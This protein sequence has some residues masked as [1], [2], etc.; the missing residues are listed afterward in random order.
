MRIVV[1][2]DDTLINTRR[3]LQGV[4]QFILDTKIPLDDIEM[5]S[6]VE[7]FGKY[8]SEEQK[9]SM[10][11]LR[12]YY[13]DLLLCVDERGVE[14]A[15]LDEPIPSAADV[16][17]KWAEESQIIL[18]TGRPENTRELT[19]RQLKGFGF[20]SGKVELVMYRLEDYARARGAESGP[21]L[22]ETR[23]RLFSQICRAY[24]VIRVVD[25][26]PGYFRTYREY[27]VPDRMGLLRS[28]AYSPRSFLE[29]GATRVVRGW[30][31]LSG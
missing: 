3:R 31:E 16:L 24:S 17:Q 19:M 18:L 4:W 25:D 6:T 1:D 15:E 14:L 20:P 27:D 5:L 10:N 13:W 22:V 12:E 2:I 9:V 29:N 23:A 8:S 21:S 7:V 26:Y 30:H 11:E 28:Q